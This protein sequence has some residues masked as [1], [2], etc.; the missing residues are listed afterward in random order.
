MKNNDKEKYLYSGYRIA[1][2]GKGDWSFGNDSAR[3][4]ITLG[5]DNSLPSHTDL[6]NDSLIL[7]EGPIFGIMESLV[8][9]KNNLILTLLK[10]R[11]S[12]AWVCIIMLIIVICKWKRNL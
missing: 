1:I 12:I 6:K 2:D 10:Q 8:Q 5:V 7:R 11:Q 9:Q 3:N 4:I